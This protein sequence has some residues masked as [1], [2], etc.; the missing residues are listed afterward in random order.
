[1]NITEEVVDL[2]MRKRL[3]SAGPSGTDTEALQG[4]LIKFGDHRKTVYIS[5]K[6]FV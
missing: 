6:S 5:V 2:V 3:G 1:M 4:L